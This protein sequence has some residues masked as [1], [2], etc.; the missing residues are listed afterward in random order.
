MEILG[1]AIEKGKTYTLAME[2][3]KLHTRSRLNIPVIISR[4]KKDGPVLL[5]NGGVHGDELNGVEIVRR[6]IHGKFNK[7][8][9]GTV[10]CIP[11]L[12]IFGYLNQSRKFP[13]GRD[14]NRMFPGSKNGS[15]ASQI[16]FQFRTEI[17]QHI[18]VMIDFH[19]G[20]A[21]RVNAPQI[22]VAKGNEKALELAKVFGP[23]YIVY[24]KTIQ[25]SV[26]EMVTK[27]GKT[28]LLYEGGKSQCFEEDIIQHG[29][30]G[31]LRVMHSLGMSKVMTPSSTERILVSKSQWIRAPYSGMSHIQVE[32]G[33]HI[34]KGQ[35]LGYISSPYGDFNKKIKSPID[36]YLF[37]VNSAPIV[38][39]GDAMFHISKDAETIGI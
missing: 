36:G 13:D 1:T 3:A 22:R 6:L 11:V 18:D 39:K 10:I 28:V 35:C 12:N 32:N 20:G 30:N 29:F 31:A 21:D 38:N 23:P 14:L 25:K 34:T 17:A 9:I 37:C 2:V 27:L 16:A 26:R 8:E 19:T 5:L 4:A 24:S 33:E 15:L 7:P